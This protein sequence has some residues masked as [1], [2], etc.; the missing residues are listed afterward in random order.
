MDAV[1]RALAEPHRRQILSLVREQELLAGSIAKNFRI[2]RP[3]VSQHLAVLKEAGLIAERR[4]GTRRWYRARPEALVG[5]RVFLEDFWRERLEGLKREAERD[6]HAAR[7][8]A[9]RISVEREVIIAAARE[10][11]WRL[12]V[13]PLA[14]TRWMGLAAHFDI[15]VGGRYE[16]EVLPD[17][18]TV[19]EFLEVEPPTRLVHTWG[20]QVDGGSVPPGS[21]V[22][23]YELFEDGEARTRLR[24]CHY[25]LPGINAAGSHSRGWAHYLPRLAA[26]AVG[27]AVGPDPWVIDP[28]RMQQE[29]R[30]GSGADDTKKGNEG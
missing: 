15:R 5:L 9:E 14:A 3:A 11:V 6:D 25:G 7:L 30:P 18:V 8:S 27:D 13:D 21:T 26:I 1:A 23:A 19:G 28:A 22:V 17:L 20:W 10:T 29:L 4:D 24:L 12:L 2:S 16:V